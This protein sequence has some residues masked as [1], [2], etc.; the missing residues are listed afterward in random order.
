MLIRSDVRM[1]VQRRV[2]VRPVL[3]VLFEQWVSPSCNVAYHPDAVGG[4]SERVAY[5]SVRVVCAPVAL[6][7]D[8]YQPPDKLVARPK[9][10]REVR[11]AN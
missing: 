7:T 9:C 4:S 2:G 1:E 3:D 5:H 10:A 11:A 6:H 8:G